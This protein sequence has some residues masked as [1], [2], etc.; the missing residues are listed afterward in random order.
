M[1]LIEGKKFDTAKHDCIFSD[2]KW[3]DTG[4]DIYMLKK[5]LTNGDRFV[6]ISWSNWQGSHDSVFTLSDDEFTNG[7]KNELNHPDR[8]ISAL[9]KAG[10]KIEEI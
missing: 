5:P 7:M 1:Y 10:I 2:G 6:Q 8:A 3:S 4:V 9:E